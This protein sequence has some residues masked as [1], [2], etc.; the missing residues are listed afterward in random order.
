MA[1]VRQ[2]LTRLLLGLALVT[3]AVCGAV[4]ELQARLVVQVRDTR[5]SPKAWCDA[6]VKAAACRAAAAQ[7]KLQAAGATVTW[8]AAKA[9]TKQGAQTVREG[10]VLPDA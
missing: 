1:A 8:A 6:G 5:G 9:C 10:R 2:N 4:A 3:L 7:L